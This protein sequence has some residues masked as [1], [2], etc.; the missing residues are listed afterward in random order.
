MATIKDVARMAGVSYST[1][2]NVLNGKGNVTSRTS[3]IVEE[4]ARQLGYTTNK[5]AK[6]LRAQ[7]SRMLALVLP[8]LRSQRYIDCFQSFNAMAQ[9]SGYHVSLF[10]TNDMPH[11]EIQIVQQLQSNE[12][13]G[14]AAC[15]CLTN[16]REI[17]SSWLEK[18]VFIDRQPAGDCQY[19]GF[20]TYKAGTDLARA[21]LSQH[22][23]RVLFIC[24][25][26][27]FSP[28]FSLIEGFQR[29]IHGKNITCE[30]VKTT[31]RSCSIDLY[32]WINDRSLPDAVI[33]EDQSFVQ[34]IYY[35]LK[36]F[37]PDAATRI[38]TL[39]SLKTMP[40]YSQ[41]VRYE[42][43]Y[44]LLGHKAAEWLIQHAA[45]DSVA[46]HMLLENDGL[47]DSCI[48]CSTKKKVRLN[49]LTMDSPTARILQ[50]MTGMYS[51]STGI[52]VNIAIYSYESYNELISDPQSASAFDIIRTD[53][54]RLS[55]YADQVLEPLTDIDPGIV[56]ILDRFL[57]GLSPLYTHVGGILFAL[58][59][60]PSAELLFYRKD[61]YEN[62]ALSRQYLEEY[63]SPLTPPMTFADYNQQSRFFTRAFN[64]YSPIEFGTNCA[65][66]SSSLLAKEY[67]ARYF[68]HAS[69]L[70]DSGNCP[71]L[72]SDAGKKALEEL[73]AIRDYTSPHYFTTRTEVADDF[74][75]GN[76]ALSIIFSNYASKVLQVNSKIADSIGYTM[77]PGGNA[78]LGGGV[79]GVC[80]YSSHQEE[81][82]ELIKWL[83]EYHISGAMTV[84]GS[85]SPCKKVYDNYTVIDQYPWLSLA[86]N[87][88]SVSH[89][90]HAPEHYAKPFDD[91]QFLNIIG[92]SIS[93]AYN[94]IITNDEAL[95][96]ADCQIRNML[97]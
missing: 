36:T 76:A 53:M 4:T 40:E 58:P 94:K 91:L 18:T 67:L 43:N 12:V 26:S 39:S 6:G 92:T 5:Q 80:R 31:E 29:G 63:G 28:A 93:S 86:S 27:S 14:I 50:K 22:V 79:I 30:L 16:P 81:A 68:S 89:T 42:L 46:C 7:T 24:S 62:T 83:S 70:Y 72:Y 8:D 45:A 87:C 47:F 2:S 19:I 59:S 77:V 95:E 84:L 61:L 57:P 90:L 51:A 21:M 78:S 13:T 1:V 41:V 44:S 82:L 75:Q 74:A 97:L 10:I 55:L 54:N 23:Q 64:R 66:G 37:Y 96:Q 15:T 56:K 73:L 49:I 11:T 60:T 35:A 65:L 33:C 9:Q 3:R 38:Y 17:Y 25:A 88:F 34:S 48:R 32:Q 52:D 71:M 69:S 85:V 20:D